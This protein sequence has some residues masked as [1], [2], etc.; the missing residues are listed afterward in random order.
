MILRVFVRAVRF[1]VNFEIIFSFKFLGDHYMPVVMLANSTPG[2]HAVHAAVLK[3]NKIFGRGTGKFVKI[4]NTNEPTIEVTLDQHPNPNGW[5]L[6]A[7]ICMY[8]ELA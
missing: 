8:I 1:Y 6:A 7:P 4:K 3:K 5:A 2:N